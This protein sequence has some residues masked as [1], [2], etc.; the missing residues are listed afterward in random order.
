MADSGMGNYSSPSLAGALNLLSNG[1]M[2]Y[3]TGEVDIILNFRTPLDYGSNGYMD[4]PGFGSQPV[5]NFSGLYKV[6]QVSN[7]FSNGEYTQELTL[8]RRRNQDNYTGFSTSES[9]G[10]VALTDSTKQISDT[11]EA[12]K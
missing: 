11:P 4:F 3:E 1:A 6:I 2:S 8:L 10:A 5:A 12:E 7:K 9:T